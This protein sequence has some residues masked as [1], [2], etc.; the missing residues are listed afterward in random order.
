MME[1]TIQ[2]ANVYISR[3]GQ[4]IPHL[5]TTPEITFD[6]NKVQ[7]DCNQF[8]DN[9]TPYGQ[10]YG[11]QYIGML[12]INNLVIPVV[13][14]ATY[15]I[16]ITIAYQYDHSLLN[17]FDAFQSGLFVNLTSDNIDKTISPFTFLSTPKNNYQA[18]T[19]T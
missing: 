7:L 1:F 18:G 8:R 14:S 19:F 15:D 9:L 17:K 10:Y 3:G 12:E 16:G 2:S 11:I 13:P 4:T 6:F 5:T